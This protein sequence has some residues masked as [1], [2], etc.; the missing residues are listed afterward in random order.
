MLIIFRRQS[1]KFWWRLVDLRWT[2]DRKEV[3]GVKIY[4]LGLF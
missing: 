2:A 1:L 3:D 4:C